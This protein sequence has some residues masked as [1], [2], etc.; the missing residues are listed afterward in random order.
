M[1]HHTDELPESSMVGRFTQPLVADP[2]LALEYRTEG[3]KEFVL[4]LEEIDS[5]KWKILDIFQVPR[6]SKNEYVS[7]ACGI[8][9][10]SPEPGAGSRTI[11]K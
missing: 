4:P 9:S 3:G 10:D 11:S 8:G 6:H 7:F 2:K 1:N 5:H